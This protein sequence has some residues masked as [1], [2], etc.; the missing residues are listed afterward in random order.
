MLSDECY[1]VV[2]LSC[3]ALQVPPFTGLEAMPE[4]QPE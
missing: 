1:V 2:R 4:Q 3:S